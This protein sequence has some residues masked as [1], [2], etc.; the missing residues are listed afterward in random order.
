MEPPPAVSLPQEISLELLLGRV[1]QVAEDVG[2]RV[3]AI[4]GPLAARQQLRSRALASDVDV[5]VDR[6]GRDALSG[7]LARLG[8]LSRPEDPRD[9]VFPKYSVSL[10]H[11][12]WPLDVDLHESFPGM[13]AAD[14]FDA[15]WAERV[16][17]D[18]AG[19]PVA[20][21]GPAGTTV[22]LALNSLRASWR[23]MASR[24]LAELVRVAPARV[25]AAEVL[26]AAI[27]TGSLAALRPFVEQAYPEA[28]VTG[29][30]EPSR[31]WRLYS[32]N[33][34]SASFRLIAL[35]E[36]PPW[37]WPGM[38]WRAIW[39]S[40]AALAATNLDA[41]TATSRQLLL[42]RLRRLQHAVQARGQI[43]EG[44]RTFRRARESSR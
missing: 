28:D 18:C 22:V 33:P 14:A 5:L 6:G 23:S 13:E 41:L 11:P 8:W 25:P 38:L 31:L 9:D 44:Y 39:P 30:P 12:Q 21:P 15:L 17:L 19:H 32:S 16:E 26:T 37:R 34:E 29:W 7:G 42:L 24:E 43:L 10:Y 4:K 40:R 36:A 27:A 1:Q 2:V 20:T 3:L 35:R